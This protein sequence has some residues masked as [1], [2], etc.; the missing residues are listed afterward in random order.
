MWDCTLRSQQANLSQAIVLHVVAKGTLYCE[1]RVVHTNKGTYHWPRT[2]RGE[3]VL[4]E[5]VEEPSDATQ[6]RRASHECGPSGEWLNLDTESCVY[7]SETTRILEQFAK[8]NLTLTKGQN[9]LEIARRLHN[10]TQAQTQL[11]RIRKS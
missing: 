7:V 6:A 8:V 11:N 5:C 10:F 9:A 2:M 4:Q 3:T 1:A